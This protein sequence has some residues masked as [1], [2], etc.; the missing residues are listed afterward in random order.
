MAP[1][2]KKQLP[3]KIFVGRLST[4]TDLRCLIA[5]ISNHVSEFQG[6]QP[7]QLEILRCRVPERKTF[8]VLSIR[9]L[10]TTVPGALTSKY[11]SGSVV[12]LLKCYVY[13]CL[14]TQLLMVIVVALG[15]FCSIFFHVGLREVDC[16]TLNTN[17]DQTVTLAAQKKSMEWYDWLKEHQFYLVIHCLLAAI[18]LQVNLRIVSAEPGGFCWK[19]SKAATDQSCHK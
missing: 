5:R 6:N 15:I 9:P 2:F 1:K 11:S 4:F 14:S 8:A 12:D 19:P 3:P 18:N 7:M 10:V 13:N 16:R 17:S